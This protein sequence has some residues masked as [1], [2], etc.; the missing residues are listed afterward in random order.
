L[1]DILIE[2]NEYGIGYCHQCGATLHTCCDPNCQEDDEMYIG[3]KNGNEVAYCQPCYEQLMQNQKR[4][5][6]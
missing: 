1:S 5:K 3:A 6:R 4:K 2:T